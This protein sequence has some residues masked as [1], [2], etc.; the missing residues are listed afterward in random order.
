M[1]FSRVELAPFLYMLQITKKFQESQEPIKLP[2]GINHLSFSA[3]NTYLTCPMQYYFRYIEKV[4]SP[5]AIFLEFGSSGH[6]ALKLNNKSKF[7]TGTDLP[8]KVVTEKFCDTFADKKKIIED[9]DGENPDIAYDKHIKIGQNMLTEYMGAV[10]PT[11]K[12][13]AEPEEDINT[14]ISGVPI[15]IFIDLPANGEIIDYKFV[16]TAKTDADV[17]AS[18]QMW[19]YSYAMKRSNVNLISFCKK[20]GNIQ[21]A[22]AVVDDE[23]IRW[24]KRIVRATA[25]AISA[26]VFFPRKPDGQ[27]KWVCTPK[28]CGYYGMC[29]GCKQI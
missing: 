22:S 15:K 16:G 1:R 2:E 27:E 7:V 18:P 21:S 19:T 14:I 5:P 10:A 26:G 25:I 17:K 11:L 29:R 3:I 28:F 13:D 20:N 8:T 12:P 24:L 23:D 6:E 9:W 4:K